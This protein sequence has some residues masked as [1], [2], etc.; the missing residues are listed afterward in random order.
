MVQPNLEKK[1]LILTVSIAHNVPEIV[2]VDGSRL[3]QV[4]LNLV[5]NAVKFTDEGSIQLSV[6]LLERRIDQ[7]KLQFDISDTGMGIK[8]EDQPKIFEP[9][10]QAE[11][12]INKKAQGTGLG[13]A[14]SKKLLKMMGG[15]LNL[16]SVYGKG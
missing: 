5:S 11:M 8:E 16:K 13:L 10:Q 4:L 14:I 9:F 3:R 2:E 6:S 1:G 12:T 15:A 7:A